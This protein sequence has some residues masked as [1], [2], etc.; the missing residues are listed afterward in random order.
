MEEI[1]KKQYNRLRAA[2]EFAHSFM[3]VYPSAA[4]INEIMGRNTKT[5]NGKECV[6]RRKIFAEFGIKLRK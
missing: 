1:S 4:V 2:I 3:C 6:A 5:L